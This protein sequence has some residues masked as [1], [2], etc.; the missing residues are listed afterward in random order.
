MSTEWT[1]N[2][3]FNV[4]ANTIL[5]VHHPLLTLHIMSDIS[6]HNHDLAYPDL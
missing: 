3:I 4:E 5:Y 2:G 6:W 1:A